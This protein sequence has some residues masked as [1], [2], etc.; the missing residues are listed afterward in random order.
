MS[1][2]TPPFR[3]D[4][5]GSLLR[6]QYLHDA[7]EQF[8]TG[9]IDAGALREVENR[10]IAEVVKKQEA[11]GMPSISDGE[12]RRT[13][14]HLDF[15]QHLE[16]VTISGN[17]NASSDA[18]KSV[19][20][21]PPKLTV[22]GKL[23]HKYPILLGDYEFLK[24]QTPAKVKITMPSP[25]MLHFRGGRAGIDA[26]AYPDLEEFFSDL[27]QCYRDEITSLYNAGCRY[28]QLDDT[29]LA[30]L[31]DPKMRADAAARGEDPNALPELYARVINDAI[32]HDHKDLTIGIHLC[33]GNFKSTFFASGGY[34][35]VAEVLFNKLNVD[36]YFLEFDDERSGDFS[37]LRFVPANKFV[38]LG[39]V[40]SKI[41]ELE[42]KDFIRSRLDDAAKYM[43]KNNMGLS[44]QCGFA[45]TSH[46][47]N[48][49]EEQQWA[50]LRFIVDLAQEYWG[51]AGSAR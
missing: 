36:S 10:A 5:V 30:Y 26:K 22:T 1:T 45:S 14:F 6:P 25:T 15:Y 12:F 9:K 21:T 50:K 39:V 11:V 43:P 4:Q 46:G 51:T 24:T 33:R 49:S 48:L 7:R 37:P 38:I 2:P 35:P 28:I 3:A 20:F 18:Q 41:G 27:A 8:A 34:E 40:S 16:G 19:G 47:N 31:C 32:K 42:S 44:P 23:A 13:Y 29:N 17:I